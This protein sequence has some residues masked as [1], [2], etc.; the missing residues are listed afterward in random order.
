MA[1]LSNR[2]LQ[3]IMTI[4]MNQVFRFFTS[5]E[6]VEIWLVD[7]PQTRIVGVIQGFDEYMNIVLGQAEELTVEKAPKEVSQWFTDRKPLGTILLKGENI[8]LMSLHE[9][10]K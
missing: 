9:P 4:P 10:P 1:T 5:R 7:R 6:P 2:K 8:T 3:K